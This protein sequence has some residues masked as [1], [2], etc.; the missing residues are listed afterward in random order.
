[1][2]FLKAM[3][4]RIGDTEAPSAMSPHQHAV[5]YSGDF[6]RIEA[7]PRRQWESNEKLLALVDLLTSELREVG[8]L[9]TLWPVQVAALYDIALYKGAFLPIGVGQGKALISLLAATVLEAERPVLFVPAQLREQTNR[10]V[11]P[12]MCQHWKLHPR[13]RVI[14]YSEIS[15]AKNA[16]MLDELNPDLIICDECHSVRHLDTGRTRRFVRWFREH[17]ET[18]CV[19]MSGTIS[20]RSIRD[21]AHIIRW[22]LKGSAP[23]PEKWTEL[24][25]WA[26][27]LDEKV[28]E[29]QR[30]GPGAL[31]R[32]C[33]PGENVRQGFRRR[34]T[35]TPGVVATKESQLGTSLIIKRHEGLEL[36]PRVWHMIEDMRKTWTTPNGDLIAE[37]VDLWRHV[38]ELSLGMYYRWDPL[39][40]REWMDARRE[41]K[42]YVR[43]TIKHNRRG[44]DTELQVA[45]EGGAEWLAW[46]AIKNT[47]K[48]NS[49]TEWVDDFAIKAC[50][51]WLEEPEGGICWIEQVAFGQA[52]AKASGKP[53]FGAGDDGIIDCQE[54]AIIASQLAHG[55]G[56]NL[57]RYG[58]A[59]ITSCPASGKSWEQIMGRLHREG[60]QADEVVFEVFLH[61][62]ELEDSFAQ[63]RADARFI[64][65]TLGTRQKLNFA[66]IVI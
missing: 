56:K 35:E 1:V 50:C 46:Q 53:F 31:K 59:L 13:L 65:D 18:K 28:P 44:L 6:R 4:A 64:E 15:L 7:L 39:P 25:E 40:P 23:V 2:S 49:V 36:P 38:R 42:S 16:H 5:S 54:P 37:A 63:A 58:R 52:L 55:E 34:L 47:F 11:I 26:D 57:Q 45:R 3:M 22:A 61:V 17:P 41:W 62:P 24:Q 27:A 10:H 60:Q 8:G 12:Q 30:I 9:M 29:L 21:F 43:E 66:D 19:A 48:I 14:G 20:S 33:A 32:F 51:K